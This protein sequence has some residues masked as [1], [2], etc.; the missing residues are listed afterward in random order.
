[1]SST[2][3]N[4]LTKVRRRR[5]FRLQKSGRQGLA[6]TN[7]LKPEK[8]L[9]QQWEKLIPLEDW[10]LYRTAL[11]AIRKSGVPFLLGGSFGLAFYTGRW[12]NTKDLDIVVH[13]SSHQI[14]ATS[15][16]S[17]GFLDFF[18][19]QPY[20]RGWIYRTMRDGVIVD[21]IWGMANRRAQVDDIWFE[22]APTVNVHDEVVQI[23]P[24]EE[25]L[26]TK[27]YVLQRDRCDWPDILNLLYDGIHHLDWKHLL[28][29]LE[30]DLALLKA[31][32]V[33]F[34][35]LCP[36]RA[37]EI[38]SYV[39]DFLS[40]EEAENSSSLENIRRLHLLDSRPWFTALQPNDKPLVI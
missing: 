19:K 14:L 31:I 6:D 40:L 9:C 4:L 7:K 15:L 36:D 21:I 11:E 24:M 3:K 23:V 1:M 32:I 34:S 20:D 25:L 29:R 13:P 5:S 22:N 38:P 28:N 10:L 8:K 37:Q 30:D 18:D 35:W 12:R 27:L 16:A 26:W 33:V 2:Q 39:K 17:V